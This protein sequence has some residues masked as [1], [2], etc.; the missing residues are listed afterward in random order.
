MI[1]SIQN[2]IILLITLIGVS[3]VVGIL[4]T[5]RL[6]SRR[7]ELMLGKKMTESSE[8]LSRVV[9]FKSKSLKNFSY[10]YTF[11]DEMVE[12]TK[13]G[14]RD[15]ARDNIEVSL[16]TFDIQYAWVFRTDLD[17]FYSTESEVQG[18][19]M[20]FPLSR[21]EL[22]K[23]VATGPFYDFFV[24][25]PSALIQISGGSIHPSSDRDRK[26]P[27]NGYFF[28]GRIWK[29]KYVSEINEFTGNTVK[30]LDPVNDSF[31][32]DSIIPGKFGYVIFKPLNGWNGSLQAFLR[33]TGT[34]DIARDFEKRSQQILLILVITLIL[35]L[36][37]VSFILIRVI[38]RPLRN[39]IFSLMSDNPEPIRRLLRQQTEFGHL[40]Q[41]MNEFF[42]Q[43]KKL[44]EEIEERIKIEKELTLAKDKAEESDRLKSAFLNNISH[45]IRTPMNA[46]VG[47]SELI[48]D[49]RITDQE[50]I[51]FTGIISDS[52]HCLLGIITDLIDI[53]TIES[54]QIDIAEEKINL[55]S[56]LH[57]IFTQISREIDTTQVLLN[58][59][60]ALKDDH[61]LIFSDQAKLNQIILNLLNNSVKFTKSGRIEFGYIIR[62]AEIEFFVSDTGIGI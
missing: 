61:S 19:L 11:W 30:I 27:P 39:L 6:D 33:S 9:D 10:D 60:V 56:L 24:K 4:I 49:P 50:R 16:P 42:T 2:R 51:E 12:F 7:I 48:T 18:Q 45:E 23:L 26:T 1:R 14:Y 29:E 15:W 58:L 28:V 8:F 32:G 3:M 22:E 38:N 13:T 5:K 21:E 41:L 47:F 36:G 54:G 62:N 20:K 37:V 59:D 31:P 53:S 25:T 43:K 57:D 40:A 52:S 17:L 35:A 44:E 34:M 55:N 46:I